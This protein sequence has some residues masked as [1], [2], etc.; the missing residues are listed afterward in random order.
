MPKQAKAKVFS[1]PTINEKRTYFPPNDPTRDP[2]EQF[3]EQNPTY[4][5]FREKG[6]D[7]VISRND[8]TL[9]VIQDILSHRTFRTLEKGLLQVDLSKGPIRRQV[10]NFQ[11]QRATDPIDHKY[12][13]FLTCRVNWI[14]EDPDGNEVNISGI[15]EGM[16]NY[17]KTKTIYSGRNQKILSY[18]GWEPRYDIP[19]A[20]ETVDKLLEDQIQPPELVLYVGHIA[21]GKRDISYD[22]DQ[23]VNTTWDEFKQISI[24]KKGRNPH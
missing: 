22:Y 16:Y 7:K 9:N 4:I 19:F 5:A 23:F 2:L 8:Q 18:E 10:K 20:K 3:R 24:D 15:L 17:P 14:A 11:R 13:E 6:M 12:K 21:P 1:T